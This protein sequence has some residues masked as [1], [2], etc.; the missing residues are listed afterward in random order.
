MKEFL[1]SASLAI[2]SFAKP[3]DNEPAKDEPKDKFGFMDKARAI[4]FVASHTY[5][6]GSEL[7][8]SELYPQIATY[9]NLMEQTGA[10]T[11][12]ERFQLQALGATPA[13][14]EKLKEFV[15]EGGTNGELRFDFDQ[16]LVMRW[17]Q[18]ND[19]ELAAPVED[20]KI[21]E[22]AVVPIIPIPAVED[23]DAPF[24]GNDDVS[25]GVGNNDFSGFTAITLMI[26][27][28]AIIYIAKRTFGRKSDTDFERQ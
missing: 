8:L 3:G 12:T 28:A 18:N 7:S 14:P 23:G 15:S 4:S 22:D 13:D 16:G 21:D 2:A 6:S 20:A 5:P 27:L 19:N 9:M 26:A 1:L 17:F 10:S 25:G 24:L 11:L